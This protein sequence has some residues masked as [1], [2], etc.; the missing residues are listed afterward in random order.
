[1]EKNE[2]DILIIGGGPAGMA[3]GIYSG[4]SLLKTAIIE[5]VGTGG[6]LNITDKIA[7]YPGFPDEVA[8][9]ELGSKMLTQ[10]SKFGAEIIYDE[11]KSISKSGDWYIVQCI[12]ETYKA[13]SIIIATGASYRPLGV[14]G[15]ARLRGRGVSYCATCDGAFFKDKVITVIGGGD[16]A[17]EEAE[18]LTQF[19]SEVFII[20]R[21]Q[22]F[23]AVPKNIEKAINNPKITFILDTVVESIEGEDKVEK[24][25]LKNKVTGETTEHKTDAVFI[26]IGYIPNT[27]FLKDFIQLDDSGYIITDRT[28]ATN[29]PGVFVAGD[30]SVKEHRQVVTAV[31]DGAIAA[32]NAWKYISEHK[33]SGNE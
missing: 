23:R 20:H 25:I 29:E 26:F 13:K 9:Y 10:A 5:K 22:E 32:M 14:H 19:G 7:N 1:M 17:L 3:A 28:M 33:G 27:D 2:F 30:V 15:E 31:S 21:R 24:V 11:V 6:Q 12:A 8:G 16:T 18:Y 4:R